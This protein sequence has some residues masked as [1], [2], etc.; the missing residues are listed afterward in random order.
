MQQ[1]GYE[2]ASDDSS[3]S[4]EKSPVCSIPLIDINLQAEIASYAGRLS[5]EQ[6]KVFLADVWAIKPSDL[7]AKLIEA[8]F[9]ASAS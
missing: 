4:K 6:V 9:D 5:E 8:C 7:D 2:N 3:N 1:T